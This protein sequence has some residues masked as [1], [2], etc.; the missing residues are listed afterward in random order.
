MLGRAVQYH[1]PIT[2][3]GIKLRP[4]HQIKMLSDAVQYVATAPEVPRHHYYQCLEG[5]V[6][7]NDV[8]V[9]LVGWHMNLMALFMACWHPCSIIGPFPSKQ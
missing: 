1:A 8:R 2:A 3:H 5:A 6:R 7:K 4:L 9:L